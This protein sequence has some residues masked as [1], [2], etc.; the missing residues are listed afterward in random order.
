MD[1]PY[2]VLYVP[3]TQ[4]L[5]PVALAWEDPGGLSHAAFGAL[6]ASSECPSL[7]QSAAGQTCV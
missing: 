6:T 4:T 1:V 2:A 3:H 5:L 7:S